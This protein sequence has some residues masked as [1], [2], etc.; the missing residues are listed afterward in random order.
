MRLL[1]PERREARYSEYPACW[2]TMV[3]EG[4]KER[5]REGMREGRNEGN[6]GG[7]KK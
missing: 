4:G 7:K 5:K 1:I 2:K 6:E 3:E